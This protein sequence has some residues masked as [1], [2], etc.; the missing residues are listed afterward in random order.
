M[1]VVLGRD[2]PLHALGVVGV[3]L[4]YTPPVQPG[5]ML[6][7]RHA[8]GVLLACLPSVAFSVGHQFRFDS[9]YTR[10]RWAEP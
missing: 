6:G 1:T 4:A 9:S 7:C 8:V 2:F 5:D 3:P 10:I